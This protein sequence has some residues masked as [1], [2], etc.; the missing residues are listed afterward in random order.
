MATE[1][2]RVLIAKPGLDFHDRGAKVIAMG[3]KDMG[4]EVIYTGFF[5]TPYAIANIALQE[6]VDL[7]GLSSL[8]GAHVEMA[9]ELKNELKKLNMGYLPVII[10]GVIPPQDIPVLMD[11][12][13]KAVFLPGSSIG[14]VAD[15]V[16]Q[17]I[18]EA[19]TGNGI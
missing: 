4:F 10:G 7:I 2:V 14:A 1:K 6:D 9:L 19:R 15:K 3:L 12:G 18:Q 11:L 5:Q 17:I 13:I 16:R 8:C